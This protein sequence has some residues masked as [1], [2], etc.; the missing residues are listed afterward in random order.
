MQI[1]FSCTSQ[2]IYAFKTL[3]T[4]SKQIYGEKRVDLKSTLT[5]YVKWGYNTHL[6]YGYLPVAKAI[7]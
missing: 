2:S 1:R 4:F 5:F 7:K 6:L 3:M